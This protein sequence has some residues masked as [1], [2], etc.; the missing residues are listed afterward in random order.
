MMVGKELFDVEKYMP[1]AVKVRE[2]WEEGKELHEIDVFKNEDLVDFE[3]ILSYDEKRSETILKK[4][5]LVLRQV[6]EILFQYPDNGNINQESFLINDRM[7][8]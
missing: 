1:D 7:I 3:I 2:N 6:T 8:N 5:R 4:G